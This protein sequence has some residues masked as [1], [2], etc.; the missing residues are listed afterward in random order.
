[1]TAEI[2][3]AFPP[4]LVRADLHD[5]AGYSSART[6]RSRATAPVRAW[7]N[8]NEGAQPNLADPEAA[9]RRYP[10]PQPPA[11][12][13]ALARLYDVD[14]AQLL[15]SRGSDEAIDL[16]IRATCRPGQD[17]I[18]QSSPTFGMYAVCARLHGVAVVDVP[19]QETDAGFVIDV[20]AVAAQVQ[21]TGARALFLT[22]P[23]NPT[24]S[25]LSPTQLQDLLER[26][27]TEVLVVIDEAY[28]EFA[29]VD[30]AFRHAGRHPGLVVLRT[31]S[32]AHALA[33]ARIGVTLAHPELIRVLARVQAPY[34]IAQ[35]AAELAVR[36]LSPD[37]LEHTRARVAQT[38][39]QRD[40]LVGLLGGL[41]GLRVLPGARANFV[42]VRCLD[43]DA[44]LDRLEESGVAV[45]DLRRHPGLSD[46][47]RISVGHPG[48]IDLVEA[49]L[50][51]LDPDHHHPEVRNR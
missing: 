6:S 44:V 26:L 49:A 36:A 4:E 48:E 5:F 19:Q 10:E 27:G 50:R 13:E 8:A 20:D 16:L 22:S 42:V 17:T 21:R 7:L 47:V 35:P 41:P 51:D 31:L 1:M 18:V 11:L 2:A 46:A 12:R 33:A 14:P 9:V 25:L 38:I 32:K 43:P 39:D 30:S 15:V 23:G 3:V 40:R 34:P 28:L 37:A 45:R 29:A 24:G